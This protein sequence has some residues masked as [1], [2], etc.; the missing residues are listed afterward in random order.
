MR[1]ATVALL[2]AGALGAALRRLER[3]VSAAAEPELLAA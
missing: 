2:N 1:S 3:S